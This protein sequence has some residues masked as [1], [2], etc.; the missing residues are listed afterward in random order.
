M[1][2]AIDSGKHEIEIWGDGSQTRSFCYVDDLVSGMIRSASKYM[3]RPM[4]MPGTTPLP[5]RNT[6]FRFITPR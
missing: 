3:A 6:F 5:V 4:A 2:E 1:L